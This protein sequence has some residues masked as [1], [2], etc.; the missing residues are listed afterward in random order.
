MSK[1]IRNPIGYNN[2]GFK[3]TTARY[4]EIGSWSQNVGMFFV[5]R[6]AVSGK[7]VSRNV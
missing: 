6:C 5:S 7:W 3:R 4:G 2:L 1:V